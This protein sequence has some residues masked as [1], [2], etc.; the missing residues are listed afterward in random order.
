MQN[1]TQW[2]TMMRSL[3]SKWFGAN[4]YSHH[5]KFILPFWGE[6]LWSFFWKANTFVFV[7]QDYISRS[8]CV[9]LFIHQKIAS[10]SNHHREKV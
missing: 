9:C 1:D 5:Y 8:V 6:E 2:H 7:L 4:D 3:H 10:L